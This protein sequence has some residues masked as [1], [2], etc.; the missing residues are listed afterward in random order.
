MFFVES[1]YKKNDNFPYLVQENLLN[2]EDID[3]IK[4]NFPRELFNKIEDLH[5]KMGLT[6]GRTNIQ[7]QNPLMS[8]FL[9]KDKVWKKLFST[10][11]GKKFSKNLYNIFKAECDDL[12]IDGLNLDKARWFI[13]P[14]S[15]LTVDDSIFLNRFIRKVKVYIIKKYINILGHLLNIINIP[16]III[17]AQLCRAKSGYELKPHIDSRSKLMSVLFYLNEV[18]DIKNNYISNLDL[19][20][21]DNSKNPLEFL[22]ITPNE[23]L[24]K[25][26]SIKVESNK[27][28]VILN[29]NN[30]FH[31]VDQWTS[32]NYRKFF[33]IAYTVKGR[34][35]IWKTNKSTG[36]N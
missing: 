3:Y 27:L 32:E 33:Y 18:K 26:N 30:A 14:S 12:V 6:E 13:N 35:N 36:K 11:S 7:F 23:K 2:K 17:D 29:T 15:Y 8:S 24:N 25:F 5:D 1:K 28:V 31:G 4:D 19:Y 34:D 10:F 16:L 9:K 22:G 21:S 20:E